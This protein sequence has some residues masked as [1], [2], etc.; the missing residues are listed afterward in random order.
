MHIAT[1]R[2]RVVTKLDNDETGYFHL[3]V[4]VS[5]KEAAATGDP[6][7]FISKTI[8]EHLAGCVASTGL[9]LKEGLWEVEFSQFALNNFNYPKGFTA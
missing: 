3:P 7:G 8:G 1:I 4:Q 9:P 2:S 5:M 6:Q